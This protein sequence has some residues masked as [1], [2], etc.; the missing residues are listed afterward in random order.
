[1]KALAISWMNTINQ[2]IIWLVLF[3]LVSTSLFAQDGGP[4]DTPYGEDGGDPGAVPI[5]DYWWILA[6]LAVILVW[7]YLKKEIKFVKFPS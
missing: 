1:M 3:V 6:T 4:F 7:F 5:T 2:K